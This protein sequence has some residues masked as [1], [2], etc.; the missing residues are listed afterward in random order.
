MLKETT[1]CRYNIRR[2]ERNHLTNSSFSSI[3]LCQ[4]IP[5]FKYLELSEPRPEKKM[6]RIGWIVCHEGSDMTVALEA[7]NEKKVPP[8]YSNKTDLTNYCTR[9]MIAL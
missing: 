4:Q 6:V 5:G 3:Q 2:E 1:C 9:L 7:I 8:K